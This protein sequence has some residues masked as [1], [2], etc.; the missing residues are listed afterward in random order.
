M[1]DGAVRTAFSEHIDIW[2]IRV[3][4]VLEELD[5]P[6]I[7]ISAGDTSLY[8]RDD[9]EIPYRCFPHFAPWVPGADINTAGAVVSIDIHGEISLH[10]PRRE[11]YWAAPQ[12]LEHLRDLPDRI[13]VEWHDS[14]WRGHAEAPPGSV[15]LG[16]ERETHPALAAGLAVNPVEV[17]R[18]LDY[19]R[20]RKTDYEIG[21]IA[22]AQVSAAEGHRRVREAFMAGGASTRELY[23][24]WLSGSGQ[25]GLQ[26]PYGAIV[27]A[28]P[29]AGVLHF[30]I[31]RDRALRAPEV[32]LI[33]A[34]TSARG[35][36]SDVTRT[37][38]LGEAD[39][40][41][42]LVECVDR[43]QQELVSLCRP[44][45][46][47]LELHEASHLALAGAVAECGLGTAS[48]E[49]LVEG[50]VMQALMPHGIGHALGIQVHDVGARQR[51]PGDA[52]SDPHPLYPHLRADC[53]L[54][55]GLVHTVE[56]GIYFIPS[57]LHQVR[58]S[59]AK[60]CLDWGRV[61]RW[62]RFGGVRIEDNVVPAEH[63]RNLTREQLP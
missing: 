31:Y 51:R 23:C 42:E 12:D 21:C 43:V 35:Y 32:L 54:E 45:L 24:T 59:K 3:L 47:F 27:A 49:A 41:A 30:Q 11:S 5:L 1:R 7:F 36:A 2:C 28:G 8:P 53:R 22:E 13:R 62:E 9:A 20:A 55:E 39:G 33:D 16:P 56:P 58:S 61:E 60:D 6:A 10:V 44:G 18:R 34:G 40:F 38:V 48:P 37:H 26:E 17:L 25:S 57:L 50:G 46:E 14:E 15:W 4:S 19:H 63:P 29:D 52:P